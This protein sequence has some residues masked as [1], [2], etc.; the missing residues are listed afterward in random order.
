MVK[1]LKPKIF[2][3][4]N[5][6]DSYLLVLEK[7]IELKTTEKIER[8]K[9]L[10][11]DKDIQTLKTFVEKRENLINQIFDKR[12]K[13]KNKKLDLLLEE[14]DKHIENPKLVSI[15]LNLFETLLRAPVI[16]EKDLEYLAMFSVDKLLEDE[17]ILEKE[18]IEI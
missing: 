16:S 8:T 9:R 3:P 12:L 7:Y 10:K 11:I 5:I 2:S 6:F 4:W 13:E 14:I 15:F 17:S 18:I 1:V